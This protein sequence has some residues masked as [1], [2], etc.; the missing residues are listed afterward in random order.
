[1]N[2]SWIFNIQF[3]LAHL[4]LFTSL[5]NKVAPPKIMSPHIQIFENVMP[6]NLNVHEYSCWWSFLRSSWLL[7]CNNS[8]SSHDKIKKPKCNRT[9]HKI[10][11]QRFMDRHSCRARGYWKASNP[12]PRPRQD[13][14]PKYNRTFHKIQ[15]QRFMDCHSCGAHG[16]WKANNPKPRS[17]QDK[18][19]K[20]NG[21]CRKSLNAKTK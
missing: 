5:Q 2:Q 10:Q 13:K 11:I 1:M 18:K 6:K 4:V 21:T 15:I 3:G 16:Y 7:K 14:N 20:C 9:F 19:P 12:R 17:W 8:G